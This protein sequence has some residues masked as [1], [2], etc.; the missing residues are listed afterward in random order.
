MAIQDIT[1]IPA[2]TVVKGTTTALGTT[3]LRATVEAAIMAD[4]PEQPIRRKSITLWLPAGYG[5]GEW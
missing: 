3:A 5:V 2:T 4:I 1:A